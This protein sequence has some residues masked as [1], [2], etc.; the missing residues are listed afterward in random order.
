MLFQLKSFKMKKKNQDVNSLIQG[1]E[2]ILLKNRC[3]LLDEEK[4]LL[5]NCLTQLKSGED[6]KIT[7]AQIAKWLLLFLKID[8]IIDF[9]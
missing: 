6:N 4:V 1:I 7:L 3:S 8:D 9:L 5:E 2:A